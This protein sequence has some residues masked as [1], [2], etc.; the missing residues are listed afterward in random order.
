MRI[1]GLD[2]AI[3]RVAPSGA[4]V[5]SYAKAVEIFMETENWTRAEA[6]EW[7]DYNCIP[8]CAGPRSPIWED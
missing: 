5:Y 7:V 3:I 4:A 2:K 8:L 1:Q 6:Q